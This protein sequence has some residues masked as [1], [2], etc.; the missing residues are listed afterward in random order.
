MGDATSDELKAYVL[1]TGS[2]PLDDV[3]QDW[4]NRGIE[5]LR[6]EL[7]LS[8]GDLLP[9]N[10]LDSTLDDDVKRHNVWASEPMETD[11][12]D[13][14][15]ATRSKFN[16]LDWWRYNETRF[17][18]LAS[19]ARRI[20]AFPASQ[21]ASERDFSYM[22]RLC[23]HLRNRLDPIRA[24]KLSL[25]APSIRVPEEFRTANPSIRSK[26]PQRLAKMDQGR[27]E[28]LKRRFSSITPNSLLEPLPELFDDIFTDGFH[29]SLIQEEDDSEDEFY[30]EVEGE[31]TDSNI[32]ESTEEF[33]ELLPPSKIYCAAPSATRAPS[34]S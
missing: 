19:I 10:H 33:D 32:S 14:Y 24:W 9:R 3:S 30:D 28:K 1:D 34:S 20:L 7:K 23:S 15:V 31:E 6:E 12:V 29:D 22:R 21:A 4:F 8:G 18:N 17:P 26:N 2:I 16:A 27:R 11:E 25:I 13:D 5:L